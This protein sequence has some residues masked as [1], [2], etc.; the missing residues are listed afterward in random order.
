[1]SQKVEYGFVLMSDVGETNQTW[2]M[3]KAST[4][5]Q[6]KDLAK[7]HVDRS[8]WSVYD[9]I[10]MLN[11]RIWHSLEEGD[12]SPNIDYIR[13]DDVERD[14]HLIRWWC[15]SL[16]IKLISIESE[17]NFEYETS[18]EEDT[19][20][21]IIGNIKKMFAGMDV[22]NRMIISG[23]VCVVCLLLWNSWFFD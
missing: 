10:P 18:I 7:Q 8:D 3:V 2:I 5:N 17:K 19:S 21:T 14:D 1:M 4:Y 22:S 15:E 20:L 6:A 9:M 16:N 12:M 23:L 13:G 11:D